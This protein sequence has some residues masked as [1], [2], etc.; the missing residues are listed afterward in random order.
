MGSK[1]LTDFYS[2]G[3]SNL[4]SLTT[5]SSTIADTVLR[6]TATLTELHLT[7]ILLDYSEDAATSNKLFDVLIADETTATGSII[8][9]KQIT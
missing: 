6:S 2:E 9:K 8:L 5:D 4:R 3:Y 1:N 7:N